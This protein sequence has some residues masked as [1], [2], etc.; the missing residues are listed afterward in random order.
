MYTENLKLASKPGHWPSNTWNFSSPFSEL[1]KNIFSYHLIV[2]VFI[3][4]CLIDVLIV[5]IFLS[6]A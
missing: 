2:V 6:F 3:D 5:T 4:F 1:E